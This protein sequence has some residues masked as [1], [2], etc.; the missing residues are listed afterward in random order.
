MQHVRSRQEI[1]ARP[2]EV[3]RGMRAVPIAETRWPDLRAGDFAVVDV[4]AIEPRAGA[5]LCMRNVGGE[6]IFAMCAGEI[7]PRAAQMQTRHW[8]LLT[9]AAE[10][11]VLII[12]DKF[13]RNITLGRVVGVLRPALIDSRA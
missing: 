12:A 5:M 4:S 7:N 3:A 8:R 6:L 2:L 10:G 9:S 13:L 11:C 1:A